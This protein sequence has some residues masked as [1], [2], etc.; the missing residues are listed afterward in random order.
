MSPKGFRAFVAN[1]RRADT[2][3]GDFIEDAR[4]DAL[5]PG[6][7]A[8]ADE[9]RAYLVWRGACPVCA[10]IAPVVFRRYQR[11]RYFAAALEAAQ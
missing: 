11:S 10:D 6:H 2:F 8:S 5:L 9:L 7:F 1:T 3:V 4:R